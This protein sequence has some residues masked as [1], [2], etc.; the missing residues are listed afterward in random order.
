MTKT[1]KQRKMKLT[2]SLTVPPHI[3]TLEYAIRRDDIVLA[4]NIAA[5]HLGR[6]EAQFRVSREW[7]SLRARVA[8]RG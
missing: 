3:H 1:T 5:Q 2:W 8:K 7:T 6:D 4:T